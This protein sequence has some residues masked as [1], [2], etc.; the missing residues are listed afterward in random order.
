MK[1]R[2]IVATALAAL[3]LLSGLTAC[4][5]AS[6]PTTAPST[7]A[8]TA[9]PTDAPTAVPTTAPA[10]QAPSTQAA[11]PVTPATTQEALTP[12]HPKGGKMTYALGGMLGGNLFA[13][14]AQGGVNQACVWPMLQ[15]LALQDPSTGEWRYVLAESMDMD[16]QNVILTVK[17]KKGV[18]FSDGSE[19]N[20][21]VLKWN[22][23]SYLD[24]EMAH[25]VSKLQKVEV[26]DDLTV[27]MYFP[28]YFY[29]L[30]KTI[31]AINIY[32]KKS[33]DE[34]GEDAY[35]MNPVGTGPY[36]LQK[37]A[38]DAGITYVRNEDYWE[39]TGNYL[40]EIEMVIVK[41]NT[42]RLTAFLNG[43]IDNTNSVEEGTIDRLQEAGFP[44]AEASNGT[45]ETL[46]CTTKGENNPFSKLEVRQAVMM[47][48]L[49]A[50]GITK[51]TM[52]KYAN[53][54][55]QAA[56]PDCT[57]YD[58]TI[59]EIGYNPEK[60]KELLTAA[61][62]PDG[63]STTIYCF[64][65]A[66]KSAEAIQANLQDIGITA[67]IEPVQNLADPRNEG[68][69]GLYLA[70][71]LNRNGLDTSFLVG[72][73]LSPEKGSWN[74]CIDYSEEYAELTRQ[75]LREADTAKRMEIAT[76]LNHMFS[77]DD[78][79]GRVFGYSPQFLFGSHRIGGYAESLRF[80]AY[81]IATDIWFEQ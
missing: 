9:A 3:F 60:A 54:W 51:V 79:Y 57:N 26:V 25:K 16:V 56:G 70:G 21:D 20:A 44:I 2:K 8:P 58:P 76:R 67:T 37:F 69:E 36:K 50:D 46:L 63:F 75:Y 32:S 27:K 53:P 1:T 71:H 39:G 43:E 19:L 22:F 24:H 12:D 30:E 55:Y 45:M 66:A 28:E 74:A 72:S 31:A 64:S 52:G 73:T 77:V 17:L 6:A 13:P 49:D 29:D 7:A 4:Q 14:S 34:M 80:N 48:A 68:R 78:C 23:D 11:A 35:K 41:D 15:S 47:Y 18:T 33:Y 40:D 10:T 61:G 5:S 38:L 59:T 65:S 62:Y 42:T 81:P